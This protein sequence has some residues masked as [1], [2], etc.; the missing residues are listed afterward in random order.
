MDER[1]RVITG[2]ALVLLAGGAIAFLALTDR[3]RNTLR[4]VGPALDDVSRTLEEVRTIV[5][6]IDDIVQEAHEAVVDLRATLA[7]D[8]EASVEPEASPQAV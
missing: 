4:R 2:A 6:K 5:R 8:D 7:R 1:D 3:G